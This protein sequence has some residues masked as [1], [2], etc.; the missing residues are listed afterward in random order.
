M[1]FLA[2]TA[3]S[4]NN[5]FATIIAT[6]AITLSV[7]FLAIKKSKKEKR[8]AKR[9]FRKAKRKLLW[10]FVKSKFRF[11]KKDGNRKSRFWSKFLLG[12]A[13]IGGL[14]AL[15]TGNVITWAAFLQVFFILS[16]IVALY[17]IFFEG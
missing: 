9:K 16:A 12:V 5:S 17:V 6:T 4:Q 2:L 11:K 15:A 8:S 10:R 14:A 7:V 13:V 1:Q 3:L